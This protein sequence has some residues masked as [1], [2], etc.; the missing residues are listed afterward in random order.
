MKLASHLAAASKAA[1]ALLSSNNRGKGKGKGK[2]KAKPQSPAA[3]APAGWMCLWCDCTLAVERKQNFPFRTACHGCCRQKAQAMNPPATSKLPPTEPTVSQKKGQVPKPADVAA[4]TAE[5]TAGVPAKNGSTSAALAA[6]AAVESTAT[7]RAP[8]VPLAL[9]DTLVAPELLPALGPLVELLAAD[10]V[11]GAALSLP[12][13]G[14]ELASRLRNSGPCSSAAVRA[15][16]EARIKGLTT[17]LTALEAVGATEQAECVRSKLAAEQATL[18]KLEKER[19]TPAKEA[20]ALDNARSAFVLAVQGRKDRAAAAKAKTAERSSQRAALLRKLQDQVDAVSKAVLQVER[21][22]AAAHEERATLHENHEAAVLELLDR[23]RTEV[24]H[25]E[26]V[27]AE[28]GQTAAQE[29]EQ[30]KARVAEQDA[31]LKQACAH[32]RRMPKSL[33]PLAISSQ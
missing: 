4:K 31:Q 6:T 11:P 8:G 13:A 30:L 32:E 20:F 16:R 3:K 29:L 28:P 24:S 33:Q 14:E 5:A 22:H 7:G 27:T 2:G 9:P 18:A 25:A 19:P 1:Q 17:A 21:E 12:S 10:T 23:R 15:E 26:P